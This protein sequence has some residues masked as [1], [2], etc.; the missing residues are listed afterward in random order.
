MKRVIA[1]VGAVVACWEFAFGGDITAD[2]QAKIDAAAARGGGEVVVPSG[3]HRVTSLWLRSGVALHLARGARLLASRDCSAYPKVEGGRPAGVVNARGVKDVKVIGEP[4]SYIDG[5]NC[6]NPKGG[7]GYRGPHAIWFVDSTNVVVRGM[8][9]RDAANYAV[10]FLRCRDTITEDCTVEGGHDGVHHDVCEGVRISGCRLETGDDSIAGACCTDVVVSNCTLNS[11]CSPIRYGGRNVLITDCR[12]TGPAKHPHRWT[13]T[14]EEKARGARSSEV[15]GRRTTGCFYQPYTGDKPIMGFR[16]GNVVIR[17]VTVENCERF[18]VSLSGISGAI[19]QDGVAIPD[20]TFENVHATGLA[21]PSVVAAPADSPLHLTFKN[22]SFG[23]RS[24][25]KTAFV[26]SNVKVSESDVSLE[27]VSGSLIEERKNITYDDIPEF[28][29][30]QIEDAA[31]RAIWGLPPLTA[32]YSNHELVVSPDGMSPHDA[33]LAIRAAKARGDCGAW[34]VRVKEGLYTLNETLVFTPADSGEPDAPVTWIGEGDKTVFAG[35]RRLTGW[36]DVGGGVWSAPIPPATDG[37]PAFFEQLWVNGRRADRARLPNSVPSHPIEGYLGLAAAG[38]SP[39]T[40]ENGKVTYIERAAFSNA[41]ELASIPADELRWA[42]MCVIQKWSFARRV[43]KS[44]DPATMTVET[45]SPEDLATWRKWVP[46]ISIA[47]FE[48]VRS[49]FDAPGEWFYD[50]KNGTVL[51]RPLP[52][53]DMAKAEVV[54]PSS[55]LSRLVEFKGNPDGGA[56]VHDIAFKGISFAFTSATS[57]GGRGPTQSYQFQAARNSD[58]AVTAMGARRLSMDSCR[59]SHTGNY[60]MRFNDGCTSNSVTN[61]EFD[62][63]GAG[64]VWMGASSNYVAKGEVLSRRVI[65]TLA[66]RSTAFNLVD[67]C[68]IR[69]GGKFNPEG[70]GVALTHVSDSKVVNC[71]IC[72]FMYTGVSVGF[73]W[74]FAG[75]V[76]QRN[77][78]AFNKIYDLGKGVMS[79][80]GGVYTL[81]TSYGT[82]VHDNVI[83]DVWAYAYGGWALYTDEGSEGIVMER[84]LCW[85]TMDGGFHQH[86]GTGCIIRNNIFAW[87]RRFGAVRTAHKVMKGIPCTLHFVN[88]IVVVKEGPLVS[89]GPRGVGGVWAANLWYDYSGRP[90]LDGL[91]WEAWKDCGKETCSAY[92]D[93]RFVD[94]DACDF[95]L[96]ADSPAFALGFKPWDYSK[97]GRRR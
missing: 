33:L 58:G 97:A 62:D 23:F 38:V 8:S 68:L 54:A 53:E 78:I 4:D 6:Y 12:V 1:I 52:G 57:E 35:G 7:E 96:K 63:L 13:L 21:K 43:V 83:H 49:A 28:P 17:N 79:D 91:D 73:T 5:G 94:A 93:P 92:A 67:N 24:P 45:H 29:S 81:A 64:G 9:V 80:M 11:A 19:W 59:I 30:W 65:T 72:D 86:Y 44:F 69:G 42:Q 32:T 82:K 46:G 31:T 47:W 39:V 14:R 66:P 51:Y 88:N 20:V 41:A 95:R 15:K 89:K 25:Q 36:K 87:N 34:T 60:G 2:I 71:E 74:G 40:N 50:A 61:C 37:S 70:T 84:N 55:G 77:E 26:V 48:N 10:F 85:N 90:E 3:E 56:Y 16:P 76:A 27:R 22:C 75:S 18:M